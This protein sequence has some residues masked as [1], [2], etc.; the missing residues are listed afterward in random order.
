MVVYRIVQFPK[1]PVTRYIV[2]PDFRAWPY[3]LD[4]QI[5]VYRKDPCTC[6]GCKRGE[7]ACRA[8]TL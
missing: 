2:V 5:F 8:A 4:R 7:S 3:K 6:R 1:G